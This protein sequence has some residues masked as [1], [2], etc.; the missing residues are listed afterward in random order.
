MSSINL[1]TFVPW[2]VTHGNSCHFLQLACTSFLEQVLN[3]QLRQELLVKA[4]AWLALSKAIHP[5]YMKKGFHI[6]TRV[7][8][9]SDIRGSEKILNTELGKAA[10]NVLDM[11]AW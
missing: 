3:I 10:F 11:V 7:T 1:I 8:A 6:Q 2:D 5:V 4:I 9:N